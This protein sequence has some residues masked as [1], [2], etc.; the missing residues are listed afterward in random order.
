MG[1]VSCISEKSL[2]HIFIFSDN[3]E[4]VFVPTANDIYPCNSRQRWPA[5]TVDVIKGY[6]MKV[7]VIKIMLNNLPIYLLR[8][9]Q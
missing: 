5:V 3:G 6:C 1:D 4:M 7:M 8:A 2:A 9:A